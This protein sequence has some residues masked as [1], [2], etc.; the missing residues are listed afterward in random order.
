VALV[1][2]TDMAAADGVI[3]EAGRKRVLVLA[4]ELELPE[5]EAL[6]LLDDAVA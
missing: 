1:L 3:H 5:G 2:A 6:A 4:H